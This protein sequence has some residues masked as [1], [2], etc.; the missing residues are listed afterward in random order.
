MF[1]S[2]PGRTATARRRR[3]RMESEAARLAALGVCQPIHT[4]VGFDLDH[5]PAWRDA[6]TPLVSPSPPDR[7]PA[8]RLCCAAGTN[9]PLSG[10]S[11]SSARISTRIG[12]PWWGRPDVGAAPA[13]CAARP[14]RPSPP[15]AGRSARSAF[16]SC[17]P[18]GP[19]RAFA[20]APALLSLILRCRGSGLRHVDPR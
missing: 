10:G 8:R 13:F 9:P 7:A 5:R 3:A 18:A 12:T 16:P 14:C 2:A 4:D 19:K 17:Q 15:A 20:S 6:A 1:C 11:G